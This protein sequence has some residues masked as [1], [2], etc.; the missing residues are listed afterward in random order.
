MRRAFT[1]VTGLTML[2]VVVQ[3]FLAAVGAFDTEPKEEAFEPHRTLGY[4]IILLTIVAV[5]AGALAKV[6]ARLIGMTGLAVG[7]TLL[8]PVIAVAAGAFDASGSSTLAGELVFGLH[9][10][11]GLAI[12]GVLGTVLRRSREPAAAAQ[13]AA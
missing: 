12:M 6:P 5:V 9:A 7:L 11:N 4:V 13:V 1:G 8:Q 3:F 2:A 10:V